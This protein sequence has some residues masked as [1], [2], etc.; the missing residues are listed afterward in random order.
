MLQKSDPV[1]TLQQVREAIHGEVET[2]K[3]NEANSR[4]I[5]LLCDDGHLQGMTRSEVSSKIGSGE[6]CARH[7]LCLEQDFLDNDWYYEVGALGSSYTRAKPVL[8]LGFD[9]AGRVVR[10]YNRRIH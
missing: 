4:L 1:Q 10:T 3:Q 9:S 5:Q 6:P 7:K 8:I 2:P